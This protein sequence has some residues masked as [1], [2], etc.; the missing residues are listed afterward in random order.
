MYNNWIQKLVYVEKSCLI[1]QSRHWKGRVETSTKRERDGWNWRRRKHVSTFP[2]Y[3]YSAV[4]TVKLLSQYHVIFLPLSLSQPTQIIF[5]MAGSVTSRILRGKIVVKKKKKSDQLKWSKETENLFFYMY[6]SVNC[7]LYLPE[8][9][10]LW[11]K[12]DLIL[13]L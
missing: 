13:Y 7:L 6:L 10:K 4:Q 2:L 9:W 5:L 12:M 3:N 11:G 1:I 8:K